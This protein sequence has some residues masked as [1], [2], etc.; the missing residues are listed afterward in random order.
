MDAFDFQMRP[1]SVQW[2]IYILSAAAGAANPAQAAANA[3]LRKTLGQVVGATIFVYLSGLLGMLVLSMIARQSFPTAA[4][5]AK[6]SWWAWT[7]GLL[8]IA[9]TMAGAAFAQRLGSGVFT[10]VN[11]TAALVVS[12][13]LDNFG[14]MGFKVHPATWPRIAGCTLMILGLWMTQR[15]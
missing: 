13:I 10:G 15:Y 4:K 5:M 12:L 2:I 8:S 9:T 1:Y 11:V 6:V 3:E 14:L 7:G